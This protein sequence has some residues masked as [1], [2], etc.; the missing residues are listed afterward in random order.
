MKAIAVLLV[1][2]MLKNMGYSPMEIRV[3]T[4]SML[5]GDNEIAKQVLAGEV[6]DEDIQRY[7]KLRSEG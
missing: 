2:K 1:Q 7:L 4:I 3:V 6:T 5:N